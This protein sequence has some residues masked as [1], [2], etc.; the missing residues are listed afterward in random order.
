MRPCPQC[1]SNHTAIYRWE[2]VADASSF[3]PAL[4]NLPMRD[5]NT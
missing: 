3:R 4:D 2:H 5:A 1:Q